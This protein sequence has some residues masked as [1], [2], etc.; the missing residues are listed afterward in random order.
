MVTHFDTKRLAHAEILGANDGASGPA[1]LL[2]LARVLATE[3]TQSDVWLVFFDGHEPVGHE[4]S[5]EDGLRGSRALA[6]EWEGQGVFARIRALIVVDQVADIQLELTPSGESAPE[7]AALAMDAGKVTGVSIDSAKLYRFPNDHTP[8]RER[9]LRPVLTIIDYELGG[10]PAPGPVW[11]SV[12]DD[13]AAASST[14]LGR[15][16]ELVHRV[17]RAVDAR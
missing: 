11:H 16:G 6:R 5:T 4:I 14:S 8:F 9:G 3:V 12:R 2:E 17:V 10:A 13:L 15:A 1:L 7:L